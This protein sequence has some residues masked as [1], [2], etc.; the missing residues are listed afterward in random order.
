MVEVETVL[1][2][3]LALLFAVGVSWFQYYNNTKR[4]VPQRLVLSFLRSIAIL[5]LLVLL[6]NPKISTQVKTIEKHPLVL[7]FDNSASI[8]ALQG[9]EVV[10]EL[11]E[12][13]KRNTV[14]QDHFS[15]SEMVFDQSINTF[16]T[17]SF[18]G[19]QTN[20]YEALQKT[21]RLFPNK[22]KA[23]VL[24]SDG[25]QTTGSGFSYYSHPQTALYP[26]V[27][28]DTTQYEDFFIQELNANRY[29][30]LKNT[31]PVEVFVS[32]QGAGTRFGEIT[33]SIG[34]KNLEKRTVQFSKESPVLKETFYIKAAVVGLQN[35]AVNIRPFYGEKNTLNNVKT[36]ALEVVDEQTKV[37]IVSEVIHPDLATLKKSIEANEQ[38]KAFI[39][40]PE[41]AND[42]LSNMDLVIWYQPNRSFVNAFEVSKV[43]G[44]PSL[45]FLGNS[46]D[47]DFLNSSQSIFSMKKPLVT[48]AVTGKINPQFSLF[49]KPGLTPELYPPL[50]GLISDIV[51]FTNHE[52]VFHQEIKGI[53]LENSVLSLTKDV[54]PRVGVFSGVD[55]W[56]WRM[57]N[58]S[59]TR[60]FNDFD[61]FIGKLI[62]YLTA[63]PTKSQLVLDYNSN[64]T[65]GES[66]LLK[67]TYF[68]TA[69]EIAVN[70][71]LE[72]KVKNNANQTV[73][74]APMLLQ[75]E[76][77]IANLS[78]LSAGEYSFEVQ[79]LEKNIKKNGQFRI[80][81][82][83]VEAQFSSANY[84]KMKQLADRNEGL[85]FIAANYEL[86]FN[87]LL[88][89]NDFAPTLKST[90]NVVSLIEIKWLIALIV[91]AFA[92]EWFIRKYYGLN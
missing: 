2:I 24:I 39:F 35:I 70:E 10:E 67:A 61:E 18:A 5:G 25:N 1:Y 56:K 91:G 12:K 7:L 57:Y 81:E 60:S 59:D 36:V 27:I 29:A 75:Q 49:S 69:Y 55:L 28:G 32:Y 45:Y 48:E 13:I 85:L 4:K 74:V 3:V 41:V 71:S 50:Q 72:L 54:A 90:E 6:I 87:E 51:M 66:A 46:T 31:Y 92:I 8:A 79:V 65:E 34:S 86:L 40:S 62:F 14:L 47:V 17:L 20:I 82:N 53:P 37:G 63:A 80:V 30:F 43:K 38:R 52:N 21:E 77:F 44:L 11:R 26:I 73:L 16:D 9:T 22:N 84:T 76:E 83:S 78:S 68:N 89:N 19:V 58:F 64:L 15:V 33:L 88:Q 23:V 42:S